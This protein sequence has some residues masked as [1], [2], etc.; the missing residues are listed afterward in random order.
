MSEVFVID[1]IFFG[2][3]KAFWIHVWRTNGGQL[4]W[5]KTPLP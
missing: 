3:F 2:S 4:V 1:N 5:L